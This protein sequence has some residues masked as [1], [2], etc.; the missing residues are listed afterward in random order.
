V[1]RLFFMS[2][3]FDND[4]AVGVS[5][6]RGPSIDPPQPNATGSSLNRPSSR[7]MRISDHGER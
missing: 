4:G 7:G 2:S 1:A 3:S 6:S 5:E